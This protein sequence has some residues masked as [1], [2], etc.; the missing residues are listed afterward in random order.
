M[1]DELVEWTA[2]AI[3]RDIGSGKVWDLRGRLREFARS[4]LSASSPGTPEG[5]EVE[6]LRAA[7]EHARGALYRVCVVAGAPEAWIQ[8]PDVEAACVGECSHFWCIGRRGLKGSHVAS[9]STPQASSG[10]AGSSTPPIPEVT[11]QWVPSATGREGEG[12]EVERLR[13]ASVEG[14]TRASAMEKGTGRALLDGA[15]EVRAEKRRMGL[16][17]NVRGADAGMFIARC[18]VRK[19]DEPPAGGY[20]FCAAHLNRRKRAAD[21]ET[22]GEMARCL[23][24]ELG[25]SMGDVSRLLG[26]GTPDVS[27]VERDVKPPYEWSLLC[28]LLDELFNRGATTEE[29]ARLKVLARPAIPGTPAPTPSASPPTAEPTIQQV[30]AKAQ[31]IC[32]ATLGP[33]RWEGLSDWAAG[34]YLDDARAALESQ[35]DPAEQAGEACGTC[36]GSKLVLR[37]RNEVTEWSRPEGHFKPCPACASRGGA[38]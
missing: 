31:G 22:F 2:D 8:N 33:G 7:L 20:A 25:L 14:S 5:A 6:R 13:A 36:R 37:E 28:R 23:C 12:D 1:T 38:P 35:P 27:D 15:A 24:R 19:C 11:V 18:G 9:P 34:R 4:L 3:F 17:P 29:C 10:V 32:D 21:A 26:I 16:V 30:L